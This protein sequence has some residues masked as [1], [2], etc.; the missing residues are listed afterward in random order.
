MLTNSSYVV[1]NAKYNIIRKKERKM[2]N[3]NTDIEKSNY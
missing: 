2:Q 1:N 3:E